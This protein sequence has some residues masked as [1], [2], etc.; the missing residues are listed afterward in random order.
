MAKTKRGQDTSTIVPQL[1][2]YV[3]NKNTVTEYIPKD[4]SNFQIW[5]RFKLRRV[6]NKLNIPH[7]YWHYRHLQSSELKKIADLQFLI[8]VFNDHE[9]LPED[10]W[11]M[12]H[13]RSAYSLYGT[14]FENL[15]VPKLLEEKENRAIIHPYAR[16][17]YKRWLKKPNPQMKQFYHGVTRYDSLELLLSLRDAAEE[18]SKRYWWRKEYHDRKVKKSKKT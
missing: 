11:E 6:Q 14:E 17:Y 15:L 16:V 5:C 3:D 7:Y 13:Y 18:S 2:F 10:K 12:R 9:G 1:S 8:H 4:A